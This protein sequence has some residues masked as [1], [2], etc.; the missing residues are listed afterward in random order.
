MLENLYRVEVGYPFKAATSHSIQVNAL[1]INCHHEIDWRGESPQLVQDDFLPS[2]AEGIRLHL[3]ESYRVVLPVNDGSIKPAVRCMR[4][5]PPSS[6]RSTGLIRR[7]I[8]AVIPLQTAKTTVTQLHFTI[9]SGLPPAICSNGLIHGIW[10]QEG[11]QRPS[12]A[13]SLVQ[14]GTYNG[15]F[16]W[17]SFVKP[18]ARGLPSGQWSAKSLSPRTMDHLPLAD[19]CAQHSTQELAVIRDFI[20]GGPGRAREQSWL[21][22]RLSASLAWC[23]WSGKRRRPVP[24]RVAGWQA[25][26]KRQPEVVFPVAFP[27]V[28]VCL[29]PPRPV[30]DSTG[31]QQAQQ[32]N[33]HRPQNP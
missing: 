33:R 9:S 29:P 11:P 30:A 1:W 20:A 8:E 19:L 18:S 23:W 12:K 31:R 10:P 7:S 27:T 22:A 6:P 4:H 26:E 21:A 13:T 17:P 5:F 15:C 25:G 3:D 14:Y 2:C 32:P 24:N 16:G 28:S